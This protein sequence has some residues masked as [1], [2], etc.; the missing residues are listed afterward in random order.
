MLLQGA[1]IMIEQEYTLNFH[2]EV[3]RRERFVV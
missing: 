2:E 3:D 1:G